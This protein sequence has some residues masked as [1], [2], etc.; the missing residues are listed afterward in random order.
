[1]K[2]ISS[3][4]ICLVIS[5]FA[6]DVFSSEF[7]KIK[8]GLKGL[9]EQVEKEIINSTQQKETTNTKE[10]EKQEAPKKT[11]Q[12]Q[13]LEA[14]NQKISSS[15]QVKLIYCKVSATR[16]YLRDY[17]DPFS[18]KNYK[19]GDKVKFDYYIFDIKEDL[20][21]CS[22]Y[23][24][25]YSRTSTI[26]KFNIISSVLSNPKDAENNWVN[27]RIE[28]YNSINVKVP[29]GQN[30]KLKITDPNNPRLI[31]TK[32]VNLK[33]ADLV[34]Y[35]LGGDSR[36]YEN[37]R[38]IQIVFFE[39]DTRNNKNV[40]FKCRTPSGSNRDDNYEIIPVSNGIFS[41]DDIKNFA[42]ASQTEI[43]NIKAEREKKKEQ[44]KIAKAEEQRKKKEY[45]ESP[46]G[47]LFSSYQNYMLIKEF[48]EARKQ[49]AIQYVSPEQFST[50][51]SQIKAIENKIT[52]NNDVN[53]DQVWDKASQW[54]KKEWASTMNLYKSTGSYNQ[55]A[56]GIVKIYLMSLSSTYNT[57]VKGGATSPKKDF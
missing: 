24:P 18:R 19:K 41:K 23:K 9:K 34:R 13:Q 45:N 6:T 56:A 17:R 8:K 47:M 54:Y 11:S 36:M 1:M 26:Y 27:R 20:N 43:K 10:K 49:Y 14:L 57:V 16:E 44:K 48:Y 5:F 42:F 12:L 21:S 4:F 38:S 53:K 40:T 55:Q 51:R 46:E 37:R 50:S 33:K 35:C 2:K 29:F 15:N 30:V 52:K 3:I 32:E 31:K 22:D 25:P 7:D 28:Y 39:V